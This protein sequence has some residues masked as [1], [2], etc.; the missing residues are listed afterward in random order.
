MGEQIEAGKYLF[1]SDTQ[2]AE[3]QD[4]IEGYLQRFKNG[5]IAD[6]HSNFPRSVWRLPLNN[7]PPVEV[8]AL[9]DKGFSNHV[10][11]EAI[12][13]KNIEGST[14][15]PKLILGGCIVFGIATLVVIGVGLKT[16]VLWFL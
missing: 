10:I 11:R 3:Y 9:T 16:I 6:L 15:E 1:L 4:S 7:L 2:R 5:T 14:W 13:G 12:E 8:K